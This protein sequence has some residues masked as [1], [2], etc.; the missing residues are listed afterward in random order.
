MKKYERIANLRNDKD[1]TQQNIA[2]YLNITQRTYSRYETGGSN[3]PLEV[4]CK[5][6]D[7]H[8]VS[9]DYLLDRTDV[10]EPYMSA[11]KSGN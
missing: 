4:L 3:I 7:F 2:E 11:K 9:V 8:K 1:I 6:A 5:I 10:K